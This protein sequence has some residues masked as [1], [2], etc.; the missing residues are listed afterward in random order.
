MCV[1]L[2]D[3][4]HEYLSQAKRIPG[5][6]CH[7][8]HQQITVLLSKALPTRARPSLSLPSRNL[9]KPPRPSHQR[10]YKRSKKKHSLTEAKTKTILQKVN[11]NEKA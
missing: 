3:D 1:G 6:E 7:P 8:R 9:H 11:H 10:A 5:R 4:I 2:L